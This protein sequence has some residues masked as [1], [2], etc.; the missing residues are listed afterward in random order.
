[1]KLAA[2][3]SDQISDEITAYS[4]RSDALLG[5]TSPDDLVTFNYKKLYDEFQEVMPVLTS[6]VKDSTCINIQ[7]RDN[8]IKTFENILPT[9]VTIVCKILSTHNQRLSR[10]KYL[11]SL[12]LKKGGAKDTC[13]NRFAHT[14]DSMTQRSTERKLR[15]M[16]AA[17]LERLEQWDDPQTDSCVVFDNVNPYVRVRQ[18]TAE[19]HNKLHSLTQAL[20]VRFKAPT[21][22]SGS[23]EVYLTD[24]CSSHLLPT[25]ADQAQISDYFIVLIRNILASNIPSLKWMAT[26]I[27]QHHNSQYS[28]NKSEVV[29]VLVLSSASNFLFLFFIEK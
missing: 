13:V 9:I 23:P 10:L 26:D 12:I 4:S 27:P 24:I 3:V 17:A 25:P 11:N 5:Q 19:H 18:E 6:I 7:R 15:E 20:A 29:C 16:S 22:N 28:Q 1:M 21:V 14:G 2:V 8:T